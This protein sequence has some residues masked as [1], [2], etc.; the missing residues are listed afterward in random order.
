MVEEYLEHE[1]KEDI[2][3][4]FGAKL[5]QWNAQYSVPYNSDLWK[6]IRFKN[7]NMAQEDP[8]RHFALSAMFLFH[9][10]TYMTLW[11][12]CIY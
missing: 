2:R 3:N 1:Y 10:A 6:D 9:F 5:D 8:D 12:E 7:Q 11:D 4:I